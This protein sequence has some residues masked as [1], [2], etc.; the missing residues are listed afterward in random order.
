MDKKLSENMPI[1]V[2]IMNRVKEAIAAGEL[3]ATSR[4]PSVRELA[5]DFEVNPNT[6]QRALNELEREGLL[7]S[8]RTS[9]RFVTADK[10]LID[11]LKNEM[12]A[13]TADD[14]RKEMAALGFSDDEMID[15][16]RERCRKEIAG[17][18]VAPERVG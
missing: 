16:F 13:K 15:F 18:A 14:F 12:A 1:Y 17:D 10:N 5:R 3:A 11:E 8:E 9:G 6:M 4:V 2:Q 7:V